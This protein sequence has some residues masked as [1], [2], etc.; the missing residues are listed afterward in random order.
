MNKF[1]GIKQY[2]KAQAFEL[3][4][5]MIELELE[6]RSLHNKVDALSK[7]YIDYMEVKRTRSRIIR[8]KD[9]VRLMQEGKIVF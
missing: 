4:K 9:V 8:A 1:R 3:D 7:L 2:L 6:E 5:E